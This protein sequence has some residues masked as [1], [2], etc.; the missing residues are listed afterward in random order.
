[1]EADNEI[2]LTKKEVLLLHTNIKDATETIKKVE[3]GFEYMKAMTE[4]KFKRNL[5]FKRKLEVL[6]TNISI[7]SYQVKILGSVTYD[8]V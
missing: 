6:K 3:A 1:M 7:L 4:N 5:E 8:K 2:F